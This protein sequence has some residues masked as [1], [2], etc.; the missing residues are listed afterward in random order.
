MRWEDCTE[1]VK[2]NILSVLNTLP[3]SV[4]IYS[5]DAR[6][7]M[8]NQALCNYVSCAPEDWIGKTAQQIKEDGY[9][10]K[11]IVTEAIRLGEK[12]CGMVRTRTGVEGLSVCE[13]VFDE[14][15]DLLFLVVSATIVKDFEKIKLMI[16]DQQKQ[17]DIYRREIEYLRN[18]LF[19]NQEDIFESPSMKSILKTVQKISHTDCTVLISGESGVG[20]EVIAKIIHNNS[21][22]KNGPFIPVSISAIPETLLESELY[23]YKKGAFT[24]ALTRGKIGLFE[25]AKGGTLFLDEVGDIPMG[26]QVK[27]L[28]AIDSGEITRIGDTRSKKMNARILAATNRNME[29]EIRKGN[30]REDLYYRLNI[31]PIKIAPLRERPEDVWPLCSYFLERVN[32]KYGIKKTFSAEFWPSSKR[33]HGPET[34]EN[35]AMLSNVW[36]FCQ[37]RTRSPKTILPR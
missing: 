12:V 1:K 17:T 22:R 3:W 27:I 2:N 18:F 23:G 28:R 31:V 33:V 7:V 36:L 20:K 29:N 15:G 35:C 26:M 4:S 11:T 10:D 16:E 19:L 34:F 37:T 9:L 21:K 6:V 32:Y 24:G 13:P 14:N 30:F 25:V 5:P 8:V